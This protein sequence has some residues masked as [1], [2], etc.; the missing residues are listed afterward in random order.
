[1]QDYQKS[2]YAI[3]KKIE[4]AIVYR[5]ADGTF[6]NITV[7]DFGGDIEAFRKWKELSDTEYAGSER[8][9]RRSRDREVSL[10]DIKETEQ[11]SI[12]SIEDCLCEKGTNNTLALEMEQLLLS[13]TAIEKRRFQKFVNARM[14]VGKVAQSEG[15]TPQAIYI[16]LT[17]VKKKFEKALKNPLKNGTFF[18]LSERLRCYESYFKKATE[19]LKKRKKKK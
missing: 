19:D 2:D 6:K 8:I 13:L 9:I 4:D 5:F 15:V 7:D 11:L 12:P 18:A 17:N 16:S 10:D 14:D 3:N 1:M